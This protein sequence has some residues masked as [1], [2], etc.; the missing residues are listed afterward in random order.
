ME[1][2]SHFSDEES[3]VPASTWYVTGRR[4]VASKAGIQGALST[5]NLRTV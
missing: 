2:Y 5:E 4:A 3:G 1:H